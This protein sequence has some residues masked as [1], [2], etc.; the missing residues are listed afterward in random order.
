MFGESLRRL[1]AGRKGIGEVA[2]S[3]TLEVSG[4]GDRGL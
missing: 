2:V 1:G 4:G 3:I